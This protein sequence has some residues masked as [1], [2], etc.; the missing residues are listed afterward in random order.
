MRVLILNAGSSSLKFKLYNMNDRECLCTGLIEKIA[1]D[2]SPVSVSIKEQTHKKALHIKDHT[3]ALNVLFDLLFE[4]GLIVT[5]D[6][7]RAVGHRVVHGGELYSEATLID[8]EVLENLRRLIPLAPLHNPANIAGIE[9]VR[10]RSKELIQ[11]AVFDTAFHQSMPAAAYRYAVPNELYE[12]ERVRRYGFH[13]TSHG[14]ILKELAMLLNKTPEQS[15]AISLH[16]G[17]G[18]SAC[19]IKNGKS[20]DTSMGMTPLEGLVMGSR[21]GDLD[22]GIVF[23]LHRRKGYTIDQI[24]TLLNTRSGLLGLCGEND[25]RTLLKKAKEDENCRL[26]LDVFVYRIKKYIGAYLAVLGKTDALVFTAGIGE[27]ASAVREMV[28]SGL[29]GLGIVID[30]GENLSKKDGAFSIHAKDSAIK[31]FVIPTDEELEI[32]LQTK[33]VLLDL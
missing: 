28:C 17:N 15:S 27:H 18:A 5:I 33:D 32:A 9:A 10:L 12:H 29:E 25:M 31:I 7:L 21:S 6:E 1:K 22:P 26:A 13:G 23:F 24:D 14:Y 16:L 4:W 3:E 19:A 30:K 20:I 11:V 8:E 2:E